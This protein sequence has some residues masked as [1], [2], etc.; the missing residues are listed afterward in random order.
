[1][2][3]FA[4]FLLMLFMF[5][6]LG[7]MGDI[8]LY[9]IDFP[10]FLMVFLPLLFFLLISK[11]G[12]IICWYIRSSFKKNYEYSKIELESIAVAIKNTIKITLAAGGF[13]FVAGLITIL[14]Q[15]RL[16]MPNL[17]APN[18]AVSLITLIY[19]I[20]ISFFVFFPT[21]AWAENKQKTAK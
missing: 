14:A 10:S 16:E 18:L 19:S 8:L 2:L 11:S 20:A 4:G 15:L 1:M 12:G 7:A 5:V 13:G 3:I 21:Q 9:F 6:F 17:I